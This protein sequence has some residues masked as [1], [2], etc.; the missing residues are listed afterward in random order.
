MSEWADRHPAQTGGTQRG[1][2]G[3][4][5]GWGNAA[6]GGAARPRAMNPNNAPA[7]NPATWA[8]QATPELGAVKNWSPNQA[9]S[10]KYAGSS[11]GM[12]T[13]S[14]RIRF[15]GNHTRYAPI[16]PAIAPDAPMI[17]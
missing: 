15:V 14:D 6:G 3:V 11:I 2:G 8:T 12:M 9:S 7:T 4:N 17:G 13:S 5:G 1:G 10:T 16:T